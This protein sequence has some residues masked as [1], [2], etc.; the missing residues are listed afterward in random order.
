MDKREHLWPYVLFLP[1]SSQRRLEF[2]RTV[3]ASRIAPSVMSSFDQ[4]G[5]VLQRDLVKRLPHSNKSILSYL[6]ALRDF[7][8]VETGSEVEGGKRV[9]YHE[10]TRNGWGLARFFSEGLP[11]DLGEL[12]EFLLEDYLTNLVSLYRDL[13][14]DESLI[15]EV[16][17][18]AR[19]KETLRG[20]TSYARPEFVLFGAAAFFTEVECGKLPPSGGE[21]G[22]KV[23][24]RYSGGPTIG[25]ALALADQKHKV[26]FVSAVG[27]DQDGWNIITSLVSQKVDVS[28][29][30]VEDDKQT[31]KT[32][33]IGDDKGKRTFVG[34]GDL[35]ALSITS[36][37]QVPWE[38]MEEARVVYL[39]EVFVEVAVSI[40]AYARAHDVPIVYRCSPHYWRRGIDEL[41]PILKQVDILVASS[42]EWKEA[43]SVL[44]TNPLLKLAN[45]TDAAVVLKH[46]Q[47]AY[48][49]YEDAGSRATELVSESST[50]DITGWLMAGIMQAVGRG[51][52]IVRAVERGIVV[53][54]S[55]LA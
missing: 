36:P 48:R 32:I 45:L 33:V 53:E 5:K 16:F 3:L 4:E 46:S 51:E 50:D 52:E 29:F 21:V 14:L 43:K 23:P 17:T 40:A 41:E 27:N 15:F 47:N 12:T 22:C 39:G 28:H 31:N 26:A 19:A 6:R 10:L 42:R 9:V 8:L 35:S 37:S 30:V 54:K 34:I 25:L 24:E 13:G 44:G 1:E 20:S 11:S 49:I 2:I 18:R 55:K 7:A 38:K